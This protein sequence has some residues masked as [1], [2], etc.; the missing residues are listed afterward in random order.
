MAGVDIAAVSKLLGHA[1]IQMT[2]KYAHLAPEHERA[3][4]NRLCDKFST[5]E[6]DPPENGLK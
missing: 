6:K 5:P 3:A 2:M 4:V 1:S